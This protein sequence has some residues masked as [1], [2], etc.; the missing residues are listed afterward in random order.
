M[1]KI[2]VV[3]GASR[4]IGRAVALELAKTHEVYAGARHPEDVPEGVIG[5]RLDVADEDGVKGAVEKLGL[6]SVDVLVNCAGVAQEK[7]F[8][9]F[10]RKEWRDVFDVN[11]FGVADLTRALLPALRKANGIVVMMNSGSGT[12][13]Y[14]NGSVYCASK[15]ALRAMTDVLREEE[16]ANGVRVTSIHP[17]FVSTDM[18]RGLR[19][20]QGRQGGDDTYV[21]A[22]EIAAAVRFAVDTPAN[23]QVETVSVRPMQKPY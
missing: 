21:T 15:F 16:R 4:G 1:K 18:G 17:G 9:E 8:A 19:E 20:Q 12:F 2:A 11:V 6:E 10:G 3:T 22:E 23:A 14:P 7:P 5:F 13:T